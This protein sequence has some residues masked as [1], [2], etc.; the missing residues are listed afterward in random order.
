M[1]KQINIWAFILSICFVFLFIMMPGTESI[2]GLHPLYLLFFI[3]IFTFIL[4][5]IGFLGIQNWKGA[6]R[7]IVSVVLTLGLAAILI[8]IL[9]I[10][11]L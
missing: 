10:G 7:S 1:T 9:F 2:F 4:S 3:T 5:L 8:F 6:V 11:S